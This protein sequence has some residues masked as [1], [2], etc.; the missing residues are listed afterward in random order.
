MK[1][2]KI[3]TTQSRRR[4][5]K[6]NEALEN[7]KLLIFVNPSKSLTKIEILR[8]TVNYIS[9]LENVLKYYD[10]N[11]NAIDAQK[12]ILKQQQ[13]IVAHQKQTNFVNS[14]L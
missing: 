10:N 12:I 11:T 13:E 9:K 14:K 8:G 2:K 6:I 4:T 7:L 3:Q 1:R 5:K